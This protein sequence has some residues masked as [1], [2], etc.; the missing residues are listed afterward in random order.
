MFKYLF[1]ILSLVFSFNLFAEPTVIDAD[2]NKHYA[3]LVEPK[4][5]YEKAVA[6]GKVHT[7]KALLRDSELPEEYDPRGI[8]FGDNIQSLNQGNC[9][10]CY[11]FAGATT[12]FYSELVNYS[13]KIGGYTDEN[14]SKID[15]FAKKELRAPNV[16]MKN[17]TSY[18]C[19]GG[20]Y[21]SEF[22][23]YTKNG[24][25]L[26]S[27]VP[28][29]M[30]AK[31]C[32]FLNSD[33]KIDSWGYVGGGNQAGYPSEK[34]IKKYVITYGAVAVA[35]ASSCL[36]TSPSVGACRTSSYDHAVVIIGWTKNAYIIQNSWDNK[37]NSYYYYNVKGYPYAVAFVKVK[38]FQDQIT[39][40]PEPDPE[41]Q[42]TPDPT[43]DPDP[44]PIPDDNFKF[45]TFFV[46][47][48]LVIGGILSYFFFRKKK[49]S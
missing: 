44:T 17:C 7:D 3:G 4:D 10:S 37:T 29:S 49:Q 16:G 26:L 13:R 39:P 31:N 18:G 14:K 34:D 22:D 9:G 2:G 38:D 25:A 27:V 12:I 1:C 21:D 32:N 46:A 28:Y 45:A 35:V 23:L 5:W 33:L 40:S 20:W 8:L 47:I 15:E 43:P 30:Y 6:L 24:G 42:P 11:A 48:G 19:S 41:P 36:S